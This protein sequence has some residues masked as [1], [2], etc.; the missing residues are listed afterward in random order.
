MEQFIWGHK[1]NVHLISVSKTAYQLQ[2]AAKFLESMAAEGKSILV[3]GTKKSAQA[4]INKMAKELN[5]P[6]VTH[7]WIG[8]T[9]TN[10]RWIKKA[11]SKLLHYKDII[12]KGDQSHYT[13]KELIKFQKNIE[14]LEKNVGGIVNLTW[15]VGAVLIVDV[16]KEHV[17]V[18]EAVAVGVPIVGIVDTN[19]DPSGIDYVIPANDDVSR[20]V[21]VLI[22]YL[23]EAIKAGQATAVARPAEISTE[24]IGTES[25]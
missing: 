19:S 18:K 23:T 4:S 1:N 10:Y 8:G 7:R 20:S 2:K 17:A 14:R 25:S 3:V 11:V 12:A 9:F 13:K 24:R 6:Y 16:K 5:L 15:P 22:D 21:S